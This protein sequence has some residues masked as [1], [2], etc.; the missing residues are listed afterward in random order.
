MYDNP[1]VFQLRP[2]D[3][4]FEFG[5]AEAVQKPLSFSAEPVAVT[6]PDTVVWKID[7]PNDARLAETYL[8]QIEFD[9]RQE[10]IVLDDAERRIDALLAANPTTVSGLAFDVPGDSPERRFQALLLEASH[11][12][13]SEQAALS[14]GITDDVSE[15][16]RAAMGRFQGFI[17]RLRNALAFS[18]YVETLVEARLLART[19]VTW[20]SSAKSYLQAEITTVQYR[21]HLRT[22]QLAVA[23]RTALIRVWVVISAGAARIS[24]RV[25]LPGGVLL[26]LPVM[27]DLVEHIGMEIQRYQQTTGIIKASN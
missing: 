27:L 15:T 1:P 26:A 7:L 9:I 21:Q 13:A 5:F 17:Q 8:Q 3:N 2:R 16:W 6:P 14:F 10:H 23:S 12:E 25:A 24:Q 4:A 11:Y 22:L 18:A 19:A 20:T